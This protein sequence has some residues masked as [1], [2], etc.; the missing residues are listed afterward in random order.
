MGKC[1]VFEKPDGFCEK[2]NL[3]QKPRQQHEKDVMRKLGGG[4]TGYYEVDRGGRIPA[5]AYGVAQH[6]LSLGLRQIDV[7][8]AIPAV[9]KQSVDVVRQT[10]QLPVYIFHF[11]LQEVAAALDAVDTLNHVNHTHQCKS[12]AGW[13]DNP[14]SG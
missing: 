1:W 3:K 5:E 10:Q 12:S 8:V 4:H 2:Q 14:R 6:Q 9:A 11:K 7:P 13:E